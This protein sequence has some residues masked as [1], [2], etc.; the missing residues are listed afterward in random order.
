MKKEWIL[1]S[2][3]ALCSPS[4]SN[5]G[6]GGGG[7]SSGGTDPS[8]EISAVNPADGSTI[9]ADALIVVRFNKTMAPTTL[10]LG[11]NLAP[12]SDGGIW[13]ATALANDTLTV[14]PLG[15]WTAMSDRKLTVNASDP[16]GNPVS[17]LLLTFQ[18]PI[19]LRTGQDASVVVGQSDFT[20]GDE[21]QGGTTSASGL[22][23][24][25]GAPSE[26]SLY[27]ADQGNNRILGYISIPATSGAGA[28][29]VLG[30]TS[31]LEGS[32]STS[33]SH[34]NLPL[35]TA[36]DEDG[37]L[38]LL[39]SGNNRVMIWSSLP[40]SNVAADVVV[41]Q[42]DFNS[43]LPGTTASTLSS[44]R[45][46]AVAGE[47]LIV[48]DSGNNRV[49]LWDE[50]PTTDGAPADVVVGQQT[51][52][53]GDAG[54]SSSRLNDPGGVWS[55]GRILVV[56]DTGNNRVLI[57]NSI[58]DLSGS[59]ADVVVGQPDFNQNDATTVSSSWLKQPSGVHSNGL[60]LFVADTGNH[61]VLIY[62]TIPTEN[63]PSAGIA[64]GQRDRTTS[65]ARTTRNGMRSPTGVTLIGNQ[66]LVADRDNSRLLIFD[67]Q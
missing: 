62:D 13:S 54:L 10:R 18:I 32:G 22:S 41:G 16:D 12:E 53:S 39:D 9:S 38:L 63:Q 23:L 50:I 56:A 20:S 66:L 21:N 15:S 26:G 42:A 45:G 51:F 24:P 34:F 46:M 49:L 17:T 57:W 31:F 67:G 2:V 35:R 11:G 5:S 6:G 36:T 52:E 28:D 30:Q 33:D 29:F 25:V 1:L 64:L 7:G 19:D 14:S 47:M 61:R 27:L 60:Q 40:T 65:T 8:P 4:C 48:A 59:A 3:L 37:R 58:P 55:D 44:P 43:N